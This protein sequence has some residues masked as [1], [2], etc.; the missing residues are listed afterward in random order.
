MGGGSAA[1]GGGST[2]EFFPKA[3]AP[4]PSQL[5]LC[6][7]TLLSSSCGPGRPALLTK[8]SILSGTVCSVSPSVQPFFSGVP[9]SIFPLQSRAACGSSCK[10]LPNLCSQ[11]LAVH[12][13]TRCRDLARVGFGGATR[14][15]LP[16]PSGRVERRRDPAVF[17]RLS[18]TSNRAQRGQERY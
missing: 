18:S 15:W 14:V 17:G 10:S 8:T 1:G 2:M 7:G 11:R 12:L 3:Y 6:T 16:L 4:G 13:L 9:F 5:W